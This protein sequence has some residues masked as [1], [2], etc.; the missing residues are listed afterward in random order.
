MQYFQ[1]SKQWLPVFGNFQH[2]H[3]H[4]HTHTMLMH[5]IA[6]MCYTNTT[7]LH[8]KPTLGEKSHA[9]LEYQTQTALHPAFWSDAL[10]AEQCRPLQTI[11]LCKANAK[12]SDPRDWPG[13]A[14]AQHSGQLP[15]GP[16][17]LLTDTPP[18]TAQ[19]RPPAAA[20]PPVGRAARCGAV[21]AGRGQWW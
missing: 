4:T 2:T 17:A 14:C 6:H 16:T 13:P 5:A 3:T 11:S 18:R 20:R 12:C 7:S 21:T 1:A 8:R 9:A 10:L 19:A 15:S